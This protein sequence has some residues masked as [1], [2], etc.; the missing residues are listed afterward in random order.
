MINFKVVRWKN[1]LS[2]GNVFTEVKLDKSKSTLIVGQ[3]G[4]GKSTILD[5]ISFA[6]YNKPFRKINKPQLINS[7]N[8]KDAVV[9]IEFTVGR[10]EFK[11]IRGIKP[12][13]FE[14]YKNGAMFNQDSANRDYQE[15]LEKTILKLN[16]RSFSQ[17]VVL[18]S[19]TYVPFMQLPAHQRREVIEDLLDIQIFTSMNNILKERLLLIK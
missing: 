7:I 12:N 1:F 14:I 13:M 9:E 10:D 17:V 6:L 19:S 11:V 2:T 4:A 16:H 15:F 18:G 5:A 3:N 8:N